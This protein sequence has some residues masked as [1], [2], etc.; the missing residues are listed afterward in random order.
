MASQIKIEIKEQQINTQ[1]TQEYFDKL[2][3]IQK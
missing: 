1:Q 2:Q 3:N